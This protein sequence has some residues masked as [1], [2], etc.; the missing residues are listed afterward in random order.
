MPTV[1]LG[2]QRGACRTNPCFPSPGRYSTNRAAMRDS[3][4]GQ[5]ME[6]T[7]LAAINAVLNLDPRVATYSTEAT[8][9][10]LS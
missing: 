2:R 7:R 9:R 8:S 5:G 3:F 4:I 10:R 1:S 6:P